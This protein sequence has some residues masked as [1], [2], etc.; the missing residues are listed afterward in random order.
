MELANH[1]LVAYSSGAR[2]HRR[3]PFVHASP[4]GYTKY[5]APNRTDKAPVNT[6]KAL[7]TRSDA[8]V[9]SS[10]YPYTK[11]RQGIDWR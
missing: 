9:P 2:A 4:H 3:V 11:G 10:L 1:L 8:L 5:T 7:V 6:S